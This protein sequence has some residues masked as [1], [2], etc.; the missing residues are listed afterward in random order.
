MPG[1]LINALGT[2]LRDVIW[3]VY[4]P[5]SGCIPIFLLYGMIEFGL[6]F[7][8]SRSRRQRRLDAAMLINCAL[9]VAVWLMRSHIPLVLLA[10][11]GL[12]T[13]ATAVTLILAIRGKGRRKRR[14]RDASAGQAGAVEASSTETEM[15]QS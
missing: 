9:G 7:F 13:A 15:A 14:R 5:F 10:L 4:G 3:L 8:T 1:P 6:D 12:S 2:A 11:L